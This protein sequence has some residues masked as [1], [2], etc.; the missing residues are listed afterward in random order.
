MSD[1]NRGTNNSACKLTD[2]QVIKIK[3]L[4]LNTNLTHNDIGRQFNVSK[5]TIGEISRNAAWS[6]IGPEINIT[7]NGL[8]RRSL[9]E[10]QIKE[11]LDMH[12]KFSL[13]KIAKK[14]NVSAST[15]HYIIKNKGYKK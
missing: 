10:Q 15:I 1:L 5:S 12:G 2:E 13:L 7:R 14:F 11:I 9:N 3:N 4:L 8:A 6:H